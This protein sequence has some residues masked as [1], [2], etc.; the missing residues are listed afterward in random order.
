M[1]GLKVS[2]VGASIAFT[3]AGLGQSHPGAQA[4]GAALDK[5]TRRPK[6]FAEIDEL[7]LWEV[8]MQNSP[9]KAFDPDQLVMLAEVLNEVLSTVEIP[10]DTARQA[11]AERLGRM[12]MQ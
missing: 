2:S 4:S 8:A 5:E 6:Y 12:L 1:Q 10:D 11:I 3:I 7:V 9:T